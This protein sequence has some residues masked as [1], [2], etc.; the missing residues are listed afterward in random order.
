MCPGEPQ[1]HTTTGEYYSAERTAWLVGKTDQTG[2]QA[3]L[4]G[5]WL[6]SLAGR[7]RRRDGNPGKGEIKAT[8]G[9][10][11]SC[12]ILHTR[13]KQDCKMSISHYLMGRTCIHVFF[14]F[15]LK[16]RRKGTDWRLQGIQRMVSTNLDK[17]KT[18]FS[19]WFHCELQIQIFIIYKLKLMT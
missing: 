19:E 16:R 13:R 10:C 6:W 11:S 3:S 17:M 14:C 5:T 8:V 12:I 18:S 1:V 9:Q 7:V 15:T 4:P 2:A